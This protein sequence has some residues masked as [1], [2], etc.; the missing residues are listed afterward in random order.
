MRARLYEAKD[1]KYQ[2]ARVTAARDLK[3]EYPARVSRRRQREVGPQDSNA[4][5][6]DIY[7]P[8]LSAPRAL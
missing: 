4:K 6:R 8:G 7:C 2:S 5:G 3:A 1:R